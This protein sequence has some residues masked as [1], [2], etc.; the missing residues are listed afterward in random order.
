MIIENVF[1]E[2]VIR[3]QC[4]DESLY[5]NEDIIKSVNH[6]FN[7]PTVTQRVRNLKGDS[8]RGPGITSVGQPYLE[9]IHLPG[10]SRLTAWVTEQLIMVHKILKVDKKVKSVYYKRSWAN[11]FFAGSQGL[12]HN[13]VKV[14]KYLKEVTDFTDENFKPDAVAIFYVDVP[15]NSSDLVFIRN[16]QPD[17]HLKDYDVCDT[18]RL[19]PKQGELVIHPPEM[20]HA[21]SVHNNDLPRIVFVFDIDYIN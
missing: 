11:R 10:A 13:H 16:G 18:Y 21:V 12:C 7:M 1:G 2:S 5:H 9:L 14:D 19:K 17:T 15:E 4:E 3:I 20:W 6:V 8:H